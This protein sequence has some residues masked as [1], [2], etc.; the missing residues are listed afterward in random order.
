MPATRIDNFIGDDLAYAKYLCDLLLKCINELPLVDRIPLLEKQV[1]SHHGTHQSTGSLDIKL[2]SPPK[3]PSPST[4]TT[5][6][7]WKDKTATFFKNIPT[8][9]HKW[10]K[11]REKASLSNADGILSV[12]DYLTTGRRGDNSDS[13]NHSTEGAPETKLG[14]FGKT[15][16]W[17]LKTD[18]NHVVAS[19][20][21]SLVFLAACQVA[22][23]QEH[24][25]QEVEDAQREFLKA[26]R[27]GEECQAKSETLANDR[28][29]VLWLI[30]EM[31]RQVRRGLQHRAIEIFYL[32]K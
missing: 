23:Y 17:R 31:E 8:T 28:A 26:S 4:S 11:E 6:K 7:A 29:A 21:R 25:K 13:T 20:F 30:G 15:V 3:Q 24:P 27:G 1:K 9:E 22:I 2:W 10:K 18:N 12:V 32:G 19:R 16:G 5:R 14:A